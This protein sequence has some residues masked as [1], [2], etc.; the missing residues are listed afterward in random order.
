MKNWT[1]NIWK[2]GKFIDSP[3]PNVILLSS[4]LPEK[5]EWR[6]VK[7]IKQ[8]KSSK[9]IPLIAL[10]AYYDEYDIVNAYQNYITCYIIK[11]SEDEKFL[12]VM[13]IL[14]KFS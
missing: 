3:Y 5:N 4:I 12:E 1:T 13:R 9:Y 8:N 7:R 2:E 11:P 6:I 14:L 10:G